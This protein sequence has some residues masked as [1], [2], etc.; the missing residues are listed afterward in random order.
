VTAG[1]VFLGNY[2]IVDD[3]PDREPQALPDISLSAGEFYVIEAIDSEDECPGGS[4]SVF[5]KL[6]SD[7]SVTLIENDVPVDILDWAEGQADEGF[8]FGLLPDGTGPAQTLTPTRGSANDAGDGSAADTGEDMLADTGQ[9]TYPPVVINE[10]VAKA[11][12]GGTDWIEFYVSG[13]ETINLNDYTVVDDNEENEQA[14]LPV[15]ILTPGEF[16]VVSATADPPEDG[17]AY[18][19][20]KLGSDDCVS[21]FDG[22]TLIDKL[23]W[24]DGDALI[25]YSYGC[26]SDGS[27]NTQTLSP[28]PGYENVPATRDKLVINEIMVKDSAGGFDW[29]ELYNADDTV[30]N[31]GDYLIVDDDKDRE[32]AVLPDVALAPGTFLVVYATGE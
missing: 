4:P 12:N 25:G 6:G 11:T 19:P 28:T 22:D 13:T 10:V 2:S 24:N 27:K 3:D 9:D 16:Y 20:I 23:D 14:V 30:V 5:F 31:P 1:A 26:Y 29:F 17:S 18:V 8:S 21:L 7:D 15:V 32:P